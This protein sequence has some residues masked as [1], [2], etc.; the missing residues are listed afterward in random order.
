MPVR[1]A[2]S[3]CPLRPVTVFRLS[4]A[5]YYAGL[6]SALDDLYGDTLRPVTLA[7][8]SAPRRFRAAV[9]ERAA[10]WLHARGEFSPD[11]MEEE[12]AADMVRE[13]YRIVR[14]A[15][16][17]GVADNVIPAAMARKLDN[18]AF[19][20]SGF[21]T[22]Q[23]LKEA[24]LLLR[25]KDGTVKGFSRFLTDIRRIDA[26]YNVRYLEAE[27][28]FAVSSAQMAAS[29]AEV[30]QDG[31]RYDL[32]YRTAGDD[33][34]REEHRALNGVTL[35]PSNDFWRYYYPPNGWNC[36]CTAVQVLKGKYPTSDDKQAIQAGDRMTDTPKKRIFR[37]NPGIDGQ[38]FPPKH[39]Y[40]KLSREAAG[41]VKKVVI[42]L[43]ADP[44]ETP[45]QLA[46]ELNRIGKRW[47]EHGPAQLSTTTKKGVNG[48]TYMDGR[49]Y[50]TPERMQRAIDGI[51]RMSEGTAATF[52]Q[53]D[54]L[55][56]LWHE[57]THNRNKHGNMRL[58]KTETRYME[59][60][61]EFVT[62][63][64][65][66]E[67]FGALGGELHAKELLTNRVSTGY[68]RMVRNFDALIDATGADR[69]TVTEAVQDAL[70]N[71][72]YDKQKEGL[73]K[74]L[75]KGGA[76]KKDGTVLKKENWGNG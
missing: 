27:Y 20:F 69:K 59:L 9:F 64:T 66:S 1:P 65:L 49:I 68:N 76:K 70:F 67:F 23:E 19:L 45:E 56:T 4:P 61:N 25:E 75:I 7:G 22:A 12:P 60:A 17:A 5:D 26:N 58:G 52:E 33:H 14:E 3:P 44:I 71:T 24:S 53:E 41:Q 8:T 54:A 2:R 35:P 57:I 6:H 72:P 13:T 43:Q 51:N 18:S 28:N 29:W 62:R 30:S 39:P 38:L 74:S 50:L 10:R 47:F 55:S 11:M 34:V 15:M 42:E 21:K 46:D 48:Y 73:V 32:Q 40:Y 37:F 31:D 63:N 36:R 16:D